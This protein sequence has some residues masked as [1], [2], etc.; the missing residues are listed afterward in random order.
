VRYLSDAW[1]AALDEAVRRDPGLR[2]A[3]GTA[4]LVVQQTVT[5]T[6]HGDVVYRVQ[7]RDGE[8]RVLP[9][10]DAEAD[11]QLS[12]D[13]ETATGIARGQLAAQDAF[14]Q[15][16]LRIGGDVTRLL[17]HQAVFASVTDVAA[18]LRDETD[19]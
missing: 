14:M 3:A 1:L 4:R 17:G 16:R 6:E 15:G 11:V 5:G 18:A 7:L 9:G 19:W 13:A 8:A 10:P 2:A 12:A